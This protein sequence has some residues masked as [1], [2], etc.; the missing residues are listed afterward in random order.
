MLH[1]VALA[2]LAVLVVNDHVLKARFPGLV[3]GKLSDFAGLVFFPLLL[4]ALTEV[5]LRALGRFTRPSRRALLVC[6]LL[7]GVVF[8]LT[9]TWEPAGDGYRAALGAL[10]WPAFAVSALARG[11]PV[12]PVRTVRH[13]VDPTDLIALPSLALA[14]AIGRRRT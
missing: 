8:S 10:Q 11:A 2:S 3:T 13:T 12:P 6:V 9:K 5:A 1:P 4:V 14:F 7:T